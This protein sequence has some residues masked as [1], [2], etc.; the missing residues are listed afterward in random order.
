MSGTGKYDGSQYGEMLLIGTDTSGEKILEN[1]FPDDDYSGAYGL[2]LT[3][4]HGY[5]FMGVDLFLKVLPGIHFF[6]EIVADALRIDLWLM[7]LIVT[8]MNKATD[9]ARDL[10]K[11]LKT[12]L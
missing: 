11:E 4:E 6:T 7:N 1:S 9:N 3:S 8:A 10:I 5:I 12:F 2:D